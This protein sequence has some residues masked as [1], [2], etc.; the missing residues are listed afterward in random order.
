MTQ[1]QIPG[2]VL[3]ILHSSS[4]KPWSLTMH[5]LVWYVQTPHLE[6]Y[7]SRSSNTGTYRLYPLLQCLSSKSPVV[8]ASDR[9]LRLK[10]WLDF[11]HQ[12]CK[13]YRSLYMHPDFMQ[14]ESLHGFFQLLF[15]SEDET[16]SPV[17][18][19]SHVHLL[20]RDTYHFTFLRHGHL[21]KV[22]RT[23]SLARRLAS[24]LSQHLA[25]IQH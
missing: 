10:S 9:L 4:T 7:T 21:T 3:R 16:S 23:I 1:R 13:T 12:L 14:H 2:Y 24:S 8:R 25:Q 5:T 15:A 18:K 19:W 17:L 11:Q 20:L 22:H 6:G